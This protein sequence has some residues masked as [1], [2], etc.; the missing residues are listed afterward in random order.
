MPAVQTPL[1]RQNGATAQLHRRNGSGRGRGR[2]AVTATAAAGGSSSSPQVA[3]RSGRQRQQNGSQHAHSSGDQLAAQASSAQ[4]LSA[5]DAVCSLSQDFCHKDGC[6]FPL[7]QPLSRET[8]EA[9]LRKADNPVKL[10]DNWRESHE[11][12]RIA[13]AQV[14]SKMYG[15]SLSTVA[16]AAGLA[17]VG[18]TVAGECRT[19]SDAAS[20]SSSS[21]RD[22]S[23]K[24][25]QLTVETHKLFTFRSDLRP[26]VQALQDASAHCFF[27]SVG[28]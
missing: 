16:E 19:T 22:S 1:S 14:L 9:R 26:T 20:A 11:A 8:V 3:S 10:E 18:A 28:C 2:A 13:A 12:A 17:S 21:S 23:F 7:V 4:Q 5:A 6:R 15:G 24:L 27:R 25:T